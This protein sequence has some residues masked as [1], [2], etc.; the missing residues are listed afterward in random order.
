MGL[1]QLLKQG[2]ILI[3][4]VHGEAGHQALTVLLKGTRDNEHESESQS[5]C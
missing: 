4:Q 1:Q 5:G 2:A 3:I